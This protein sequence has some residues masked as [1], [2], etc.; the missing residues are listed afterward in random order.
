MRVLVVGA[1]YWGPNIVRNLLEFPEVESIGISDLDASKAQKLVQR[2]PRTHV[3]E[4]APAVFSD[5]Y[6]VAFIVT[7]VHTHADLAR[8]ALDAG[9][10]VMVEKPLTRT[11]D[12][13][14]DLIAR[15]EQAD[16][17]LMVGHVFH[18]KPEVRALAE[19]AKSG[20]LGKIRYM[21]SVRVNL[22][23][24]RPDVNVMWDLAPHDLTIFEAVLGGRMPKRVAAVGASHVPHPTSPQETMVHLSLDYGDGLMGHVHVNWYSP[25]K[26]RLMVVAGDKKMAVYDDINTAEP[27]KVYDRGTYDPEQDTPAYPSL[28]TG[29]TFIPNIRQEEPLKLQIREFFNA[30]K[31]GRAPETD[32]HSGLRVIRILETAMRSLKEDG[33]FVEVA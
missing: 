31:E 22:G 8:A 13:A 20:E 4:S 2:Y 7:P 21:D 10:H 30:I 19:L 18:Y 24:F 29:H 23:L 28:R 33:R 12:E 26:Q 17:R 1:G 15:A 32:G 14:K 3:A 27:I 25:L 6:D 11:S 5:R 9:L 16:R